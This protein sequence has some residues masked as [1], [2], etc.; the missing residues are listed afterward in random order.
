MRKVFQNEIFTCASI[1]RYYL[2]NVFKD[3]FQFVPL[4]DYTDCK[5]INW[6]SNI[7]ELNISLMNYFNLTEDE[8]A[9]IEQLIKPMD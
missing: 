4:F 2:I 5:I 9:Y 7:Q 6:D 3:S 1:Y 8:I